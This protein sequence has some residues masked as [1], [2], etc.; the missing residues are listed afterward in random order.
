MH[1]SLITLLLLVSSA[2]PAPAP[3][4]SPPKVARGTHVLVNGHFAQGEWSDATAVN[5]DSNH[6]L[7]VK[8]DDRYLY[9]AI[10]FLQQKHSGLDLALASPPGETLGL[11][12]SS[13]LATR[14]YRPEGWTDY[15]WRAET[16]GANVIGT[17]SDGGKMRV[18]E[19][20][21]FEVQMNRS[22]LRG[23]ELFVRIE[24]KRPA[25]IFPAD[26]RDGD[27]TGWIRLGL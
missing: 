22:L 23:N 13:A 25:V 27:F 12:V 19:P 14:T 18:V 8:Q 4:G 3:Q 6:K 20:D 11:H 10:E 16:W 7:M 9:L 24:L 1:A 5:L 21:G 2:A 15:D 26:S 17:I